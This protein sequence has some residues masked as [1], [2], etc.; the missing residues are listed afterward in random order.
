MDLW[1]ESGG[2]CERNFGGLIQ[3]I[4]HW[5]GILRLMNHFVAISTNEI[6][7]DM[8]ISMCV[9]VHFVFNFVFFLQ[10]MIYVSGFLFVCRE[11][12]MSID[13]LFAYIFHCHTST[14]LSEDLQVS[15]LNEAVPGSVKSVFKAW[16]QR[17]NSSEVGL[18]CGAC[19]SLI[20]FSDSLLFNPHF[21]IR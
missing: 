11:N 3:K 16:E 13:Q 19:L 12:S 20:Y 10:L 4:F 6:Q 14:F 15:A 2:P 1:R 18:V 21:F 17:L 5:A 7:Q 8:N 9:L